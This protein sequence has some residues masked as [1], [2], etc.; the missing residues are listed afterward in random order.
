[1]SERADVGLLAGIIVGVVIGVGIGLMYAPRPGEETRRLWKQDV[2]RMAETVGAALKK[3]RRTADNAL[4]SIET[5]F[6]KASEAARDLRMMA[7]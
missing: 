4:D 1:V 7:S 2:G 6:R 5:A 3:A